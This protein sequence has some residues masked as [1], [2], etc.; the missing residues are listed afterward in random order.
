MSRLMQ[1][2]IDTIHEKINLNDYK[3]AVF[4]TGA[5]LSKESG[6][7]TYRGVGGIW[8]SYNPEQ[9]ACQQAFDDDP[10]KVLD[11]HQ[12]R[13][14]N[15]MACM[16][17]QAHLALANWQNQFSELKI[18]TQNIDGLHQRAGSS[19]VIEL[20]GSLFKLRCENH[21]VREDWGGEYMNRKC[22]LCGTWL[23]P[24]IV[25][26][27]DFLDD[28]LLQNAIHAIKKCDLFVAIGTSGVVWPAAGLPRI[29]REHGAFCVEV[30]PQVTEITP[31]YHRHIP[32]LATRA[33]GEFYIS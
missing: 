5:G 6:I 31:I 29:A 26:F 9:F 25:W 14:Q 15:A 22:E 21:P 23:R 18:I 32:L 3:H 33:L 27:G 19:H 7:P 30:N 24:H 4:F 1:S 13:R 28:E 10:Q 16:P 20:H 2:N 11:F 12:V 8:N 17:N